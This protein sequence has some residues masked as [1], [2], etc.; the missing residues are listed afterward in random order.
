MKLQPPSMD[1]WLRE[2]KADP[3]AP[4]IGMYLTHNGT[5][6]QTPR[7][8]VRYGAQDTAP[9]AAMEFSYDPEA[10]AAAVAHAR[11]MEGIFYVRVWLNQGLLDVGDD[12]M[13]ILIG[14]DIRPHAI[15]ALQTLVGEIKNH[16]VCETEIYRH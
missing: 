6:R 3:G 2:A 16:C 9:V 5:V 14:A 15:D 11:R 8:A 4:R 10:V 1:Q 7:A 12:I 13:Y